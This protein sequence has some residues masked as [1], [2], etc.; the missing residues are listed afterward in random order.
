MGSEFQQ[1]PAQR[2]PVVNPYFE[3]T[4]D[5]PNKPFQG[6]DP[7][8]ASRAWGGTTATSEFR[9][10][11]PPA[12]P[13]A[14]PAQPN[15]VEAA[16]AAEPPSEFEQG[17]L[18]YERQLREAAANQ[19]AILAQG[20][21][22]GYRPEMV[23][24]V[25]E[26]EQAYRQSLSGIEDVQAKTKKFQENPE[27]ARLMAEQS[28]RLK[29][30]AADEQARMGRMTDLGRQQKA[31]FDEMAGKVESFKVDPDRLFGQ[32]G[33]RAMTNFSLG[34]ANLLS[35][36][37][38]AMQGKAGTN[39]V[40]GFVRDRI[41]QD[42]ALQENDYQRMLQGYNVRRNGLMDAIQMIGNERQGAEA[43]AKQQGL[44]YADQIARL[45]QGVTDAQTRNTLVQAHSEILRGLGMAKQGLEQQNVGARNAAA[46]QAAAAAA[47]RREM[48]AQAAQ[49]GLGEK[50]QA[51]VAKVLEKAD[52]QQLMTRT[53]DLAAVRKILGADPNSAR[54]LRGWMGAVIKSI[55]EDKDRSTIENKIASMAIESLSPN[56]QKLAAAWQKYIG[57]RLRAQ[58]GTAITPAERSLFDLSFYTS[59]D[60]MSRLIDNEYGQVKTEA[61]SLVSSSPF[62]PGSLAQN[63]LNSKMLPFVQG[64]TEK[65]KEAPEPVTAT[66]KPI[67]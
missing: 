38:E 7:G 18:D 14:P 12:A 49:V 47:R 29:Q 66:G 17:A 54:E 63:F 6:P 67:K 62:A 30:S 41:A 57:G 45:A 4:P 33:Q 44:V 36:V 32:G 64:Y 51:E 35:N 37:G 46:A 15:P 8:T 52:K 10:P 31:L 16:K 23:K 56:A 53:Q 2:K 25:P 11:Y 21:G 43:L 59:P 22:G 65:P 42:V 60:N 20:G 40:L 34:L 28:A 9:N 1:P 24:L 50:D 27:R 58:G 61:R 3:S 26:L 48:M 19:Q 39:A 55:G 5:D 13:A